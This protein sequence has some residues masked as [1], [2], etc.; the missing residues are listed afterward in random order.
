[1][2]TEEYRKQL[3]ELHQT[4]RWGTG[5]RKFVPDVIRVIDQ[6]K[7]VEPT[8]LDYGAGEQTLEH[9]LREVLPS[10]RVTSYDPGIPGI[11]TRPKG[12][13]D[14][15]V[16]TDVLEH[17]EPQYVDDTLVLLRKLT[18]KVAILNIATRPAKTILPDGRNA[19][20]TVHPEKW[21]AEKL[22]RHFRKLV[23]ATNAGKGFSVYAYP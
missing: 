1:M 14:I 9:T 22:N 18:G 19:H 11:D 21:W 5:G 3:V 8:L 20:L 7:L 13:W 6:L 15:V 4:Q 23:L 16:C 2:I 12:T 10:V 17:V